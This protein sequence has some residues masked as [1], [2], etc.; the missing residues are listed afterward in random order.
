MRL[1]WL[2][3]FVAGFIVAAI[4]SHV[5]VWYVM[6]A[7]ANDMRAADVPRSVVAATPAR[8]PANAPPPLQP[9]VG[10]DRT[11]PADLEQMHRREDEVF[12]HLGWRRDPDTGMFVPPAELV[13][14]VS[15]RGNATSRPTTT[16]RG[17]P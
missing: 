7:F 17:A 1:R 11:A 3:V 14:M 10:H 8:P 6:K 16:Q 15:A 12:E 4:V 9:S 5:A 13:S 2:A